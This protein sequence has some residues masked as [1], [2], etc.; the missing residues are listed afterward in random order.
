M[1]SILTP[2]F[3]ESE[4]LP[5]LY[6]RLA[7]AMSAL[8]VDWEWLIVDDHSRDDT[9]AIVRGLVAADPRVRGLRLA[10]NSGSHVAIM[11]ALHH[12]EGDAAVLLAA[13]LQDPPEFLS[14]LIEPWRAGAQVVWAVRRQHPGDRTHRGFAALY[15]WIMRKPV[16]MS[17][18]P[19]TGADFF[20]IDRVVI[21]AFRQSRERNTSVFALISWLGFRQAQIEYD[22]QPRA[23][24]R[25]G[26]TLARKITLVIDSIT[27]FSDFPL[28]WCL[29]AGTG[30]IAL[31]IVTGLIGLVTLPS[32]RAG[33]LFIVGLM[34]GL[35]GLQLAALAIIGQYV[36]RALDEA[37]GR[38]AWVIEASAGAVKPAQA[39]VE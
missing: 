36:Y 7:A 26:W 14:A 6:Q 1:I 11:C 27:A 12:V 34:V 13:D 33:L 5:A 35:S 32:L 38:P 22:K 20:L 30:L 8:G 17:E 21:D 4:N 25:S 31:G 9:F 24:G 28:R 2:A 23:S 18:I 3:N 29:Y 10:H 16:G 19:A 37:R 15:Y 39:A